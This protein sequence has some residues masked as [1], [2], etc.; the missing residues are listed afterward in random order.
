MHNSLKGRDQWEDLISSVRKRGIMLFGG[1]D[2][3]VE[4]SSSGYR[5]PDCELGRL[6]QMYRFAVL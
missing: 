1:G 3:L 2:L 6:D 4:V 5:E